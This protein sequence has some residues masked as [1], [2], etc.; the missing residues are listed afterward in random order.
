MNPIISALIAGTNHP[1]YGKYEFDSS[2]HIRYQNEIDVSGHNHNCRRRICIE[3]NID[4]GEGY[5]I[6]ILN[7]DGIHPLWGNNIQMSPKPMK[8]VSHSE[9]TI[10]LI[11]FGLDWIGASFSNYGIIIKFS[12]DIIIEVILNM[13]DRNTAI[14]YIK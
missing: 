10:E 8:I 1:A 13:F 9:D 2:D 6:T 5:T 3:N 12:N 7:L 4:G 14:R 11:G